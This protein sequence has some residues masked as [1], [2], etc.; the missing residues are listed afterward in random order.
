M[1]ISSSRERQVWRLKPGKAAL[2]MEDIAIYFGNYTLQQF[3]RRALK[4]NQPFKV[5]LRKVAEKT[6]DL[7][8]FI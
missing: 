5:D 4:V 3:A 2:Q 7:S 6:S 1:G 8:A